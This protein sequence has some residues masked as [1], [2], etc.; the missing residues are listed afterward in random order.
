METDSFLCSS[1]TCSDFCV[2]AINQKV[3]QFVHDGFSM[4]NLTHLFFTTLIIRFAIFWSNM[5]HTPAGPTC[6]RKTGVD[7][8]CS[9]FCEIST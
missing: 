9:D 8:V 7:C 1:P 2:Q 6:A 3:K 4:Q 5:N